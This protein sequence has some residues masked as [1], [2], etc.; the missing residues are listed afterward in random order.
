MMDHFIDLQINM[1]SRNSFAIYWSSHHAHFFMFG[2]L[3]RRMFA[4]SW[5]A[6]LLKLFKRRWAFLQSI[7]SVCFGKV[8]NNNKTWTAL[9]DFGMR[10][11][12]D[13]FLAYHS[14][15]SRCLHGSVRPHD[16]ETNM[17]TMNRWPSV[18]FGSSFFDRQGG[19]GEMAD[20]DNSDKE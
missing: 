5:N 2:R 9:M 20:E 19:S 13:I 11:W 4:W 8:R 6:S 14:W 1:D 15:I 18:S 7:L 17:A 10:G 12:N 16:P 3:F